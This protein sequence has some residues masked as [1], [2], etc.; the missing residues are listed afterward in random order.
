MPGTD[1][2]EAARIVVGEL[3]QLPHLPELPD[4]GVGADMIG[5]TAALLVD[6]AVELV[7]SGYRVTAR[8]GRDHRHGVDLLRTD[9]DALE[10]AVD[11]A[12]IRPGV[13]KVQAAGPWTL[14][15]EV[16]LHSGHKVL[17][18][19]GALREF[20]ASLA[21]GLRVHATE[22]SRRLGAKTVVQLDEPD[23]PAVLAGSVPT[24]SGYGTVPAVPEGEAV[25]LLRGVLDALP[26]PRIVHCC[27][28][29]PPLA[30]LRRAG[31]DALAVDAE[32]LVGAPRATV[33]AL[34][35]AWDAEVSVLLGLVPAMP[36]PS[37]PTLTGLAQP[38][39][40]LVDRL[41]VNRA[42]LAERCL[43]TP[44]CGLAGATL[45]WARRALTLARELGQAFI[46]P[47][48]SWSS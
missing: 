6:L 35:E 23:L 17:T 44:S 27:A 22:V 37:Q 47:P 16:E 36:P 34:G 38:A 24:P 45:S 3:P 48:D 39:L 30:L 19:P 20:S 14:A 29:R 1:A 43:P 5:R 41:G 8:P 4:R 32:L 42:L 26:A 10:E 12:G 40:D 2:L 7:P 25:E 28:P 9:L 33:D 18:D 11:S 21:E 13:I 46:D 31:A 15:A